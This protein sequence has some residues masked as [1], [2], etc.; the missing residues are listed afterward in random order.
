M[1]HT[2][3]LNR[4]IRSVK[5]A[6]QIT[7]AMEIV[8]ASRMRRV[9]TSAANAKIYAQ[10]TNSIINR[11]TSSQEAKHHPFFR[12]AAEGASLYVI[13]SSDRGLA[14]AFNANIFTAALSSFDTNRAANTKP[15][16]I[17]FG[18][19]GARYLARFSDIDLIGE[20]EDIADAPDVNVFAPVIESINHGLLAGDFTTVK[21]IYTQFDSTLSQ[22]VI[23]KQLLP[24]AAEVSTDP[25]AT[26]QLAYE[27][28]PS[29]EAVLESALHL[30]LE[31]QLMR[32]RTDSSA[33]EY[34]M[35][36]MAMN[37]A[38]RNAGELIDNLTL[39]LNATRQSIITQ[40]IAEIT[41]GVA[42]LS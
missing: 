28:E 37:S 2:R 12:P 3:L 19:K 39:E 14:G 20:Y 33:S 25:G 13:F 8:A 42:A 21:L 38:N 29:I 11:I 16:V 36:M 22:Q 26:R 7:K 30:Y 40:E 9:Q 31:A 15:L 27:F 4:R 5:N 41:G 18:R 32:A 35:R 6:K 24:V 1:A 23:S 17:I 10:A 34:A